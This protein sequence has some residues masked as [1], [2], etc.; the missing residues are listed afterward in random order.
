MQLLLPSVKDANIKVLK[1]SLVPC[2]QVDPPQSVPSQRD[3]LSRG[4]CPTQSVPSLEEGELGSGVLHN[5]HKV[6]HTLHWVW[7]YCVQYAQ[8]LTH[9]GDR[10]HRTRVQHTLHWCTRTKKWWCYILAYDV[11]CAQYS[12]NTDRTQSK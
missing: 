10:R 3:L 4:Q 2:Y 5:M 7:L 11:Q 1:L 8:G 12:P 6:Q 9:T